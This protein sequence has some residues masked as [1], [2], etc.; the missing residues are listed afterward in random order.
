MKLLYLCQRI[1]YPPDRGDRIPVF[2]HIKHLRQ[3]HEVVVGSL[4]HTGTRKNAEDLQRELGIRI[5]AP[6]HSA[7]QRSKEMLRAL[8]KRMP[9]SL[10]YFRNPELRTQI[11]EEFSKDPFDAIIVFSS[12]MAPYVER[13]KTIPRIMHFC[14]VDSQKWASMAKRS[15]GL[16]RWIYGRESRILLEYERTI[17]ADFSVSCVVSQNEA[18]LF[19]SHIPG[20]PVQVIE[21]GVD[22][23]YFASVPRKPEG[24]KII[25][26]GVMDYPPNV[27]AVSFFAT[28]VW[29]DIRAAYP[30]ARFVIVGSRPSKKVQDLAKI[31]GVDVTGYVPD[32]RTYLSAATISIAPLA[33]ARGVQNKILEAMAAGVP[34]LTT[35]A[36]AKGLPPGAER[37]VFT[38]ERETESFASRLLELLKD[39]IARDEKA[40]EAQRFVKQYC[41]WE[42]KLKALDGLLAQIQI[43]DKSHDAMS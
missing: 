24:L 11:D 20:I 35:P 28:K 1:P 36:V 37:F 23:E 3:N 5:I 21:N 8:L 10:G 33:I 9:L 34:V 6:D 19:R 42:N 14:D 18:D 22:V 7:F 15:H 31:P 17:A 4:A 13:F 39:G 38:A 29:E 27:E 26:V 32:I 2:H 43:A 30:Q 12:S 25:F 16:T 41:T 40:Q